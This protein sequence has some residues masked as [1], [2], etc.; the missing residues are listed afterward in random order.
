M[1]LSRALIFIIAFQF[2]HSISAQTQNKVKAILGL[3]KEAVDPEGCTKQKLSVYLA[4]NLSYPAIS[5]ENSN[6]GTLIIRFIVNKEG[7]IEDPTVVYS[8]D[9]YVAAEAKLMFEKMKTDLVWIPGTSNGDL[10]N[11]Y[12]STPAYF[13]LENKKRNLI[14][15]DELI[16][17]RAAAFTEF[18]LKRKSLSKLLR[19]TTWNNDFWI[20][21]L[22]IREFKSLSIEIKNRNINRSIRDLTAVDQE[23]RELLLSAQKGDEIRITIQELHNEEMKEIEKVVY[24][25]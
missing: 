3:C 16:C 24:V 10:A 13:S 18:H 9:K 2:S 14:N 6:E 22:G 11:V 4:K 25:K 20:Y 23:L 12:Y 8:F 17:E 1:K 7:R 5:I 19:E 15:I 21:R